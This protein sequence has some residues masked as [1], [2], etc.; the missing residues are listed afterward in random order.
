MRKTVK[1]CQSMKKTKKW[2]DKI[3]KMLFNMFVKTIK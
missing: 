2:I 1:K 3:V